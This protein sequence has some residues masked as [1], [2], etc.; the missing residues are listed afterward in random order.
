MIYYTPA[1][2]VFIKHMVTNTPITERPYWE[3]FYYGE[4]SFVE[5]IFSIKNVLLGIGLVMFFVLY[6]FVGDF[7]DI[8]PTREF[9]EVLFMRHIILCFFTAVIFS[10]RHNKN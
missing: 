8:G 7:I 1:V 3:P 6:E 4:N 10:L 9:K 2:V 5:E